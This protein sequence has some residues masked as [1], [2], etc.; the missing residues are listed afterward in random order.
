MTLSAR[1]KA[2]RTMTFKPGPLRQL[3]CVGLVLTGFCL[4]ANSQEDYVL[5][6]LK[7]D[8]VPVRLRPLFLERLN[9]YIEY[10]RTQ[11]WD[12]IEDF[13]PCYSL[14]S[15]GRHIKSYSTRQAEE[16]LSDIK[17]QQI[18][19]FTLQSIWIGTENFNVPL[20]RKEWTIWGCAEYKASTGEIQSGKAMVTA[21][22]QNRK[23]VF[24][25]ITLIKKQDE[26]GPLSC[27][28]PLGQRNR[29]E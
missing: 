5:N 3:I 12:K 11:R 28:H 1:K 20:H 27:E 29:K 8:R 16:L 4:V 10:Q 2:M 18:V 14:V 21:Y 25:L 6:S 19:G 23:W 24:G 7:N 22:C 15:P 9:L 26:S 13:L 17:R